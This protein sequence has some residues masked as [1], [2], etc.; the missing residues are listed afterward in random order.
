MDRKDILHM[1]KYE[2]GQEI[3]VGGIITITGIA[4]NKNGNPVYDTDRGVVVPE[5]LIERLEMKPF[6]KAQ[7]EQLNM[8]VVCVEATD[9]SVTVGKAYTVENGVFTWDNGIE[10]STKASTIEQFN[11]RFIAAKFIE[12][13]GE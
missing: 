4:H 2:I 1:N 9:V 13:K 8:R 5:L 7:P 12:F 10:S 6:E 11:N 3:P